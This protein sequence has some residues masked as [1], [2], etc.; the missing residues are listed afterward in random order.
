MASS[1]FTPK[2]RPRRYLKGFHAVI[3]PRGNPQEG[4]RSEMN[5]VIWPT[6]T[7]AIEY[8]MLLADDN[9]SWGYGISDCTIT[10]CEGWTTQI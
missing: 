6:E 5:L 2:E 3:R 7:E 10:P 9:F 1:C 8:C 4:I